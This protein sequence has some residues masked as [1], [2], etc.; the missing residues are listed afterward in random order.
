MFTFYLNDVL[1]FKCPFPRPKG[2]KQYGCV[3]M[4]QRIY[5]T[6]Y[7]VFLNYHATWIERKKKVGFF[8]ILD[9]PF[10]MFAVVYLEH[11]N[12]HLFLLPHL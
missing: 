5:L 1:L 6:I 8:K 10:E 3:V 2:Y 12:L 11:A 4:K 7:T 9:R